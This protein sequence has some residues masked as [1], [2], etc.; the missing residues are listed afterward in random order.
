[1]IKDIIVFNSFISRNMT[2]L[3]PEINSQQTDTDIR[4]GLSVS[5]NFG[6]DRTPLRE[7]S[8]QRNMAI[9][10]DLMLQF[11]LNICEFGAVMLSDCCHF[12]TV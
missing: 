4:E 2:G 7:L 10:H 8:S 9:W 6:A 12:H 1:M 3:N 5:V 11:A